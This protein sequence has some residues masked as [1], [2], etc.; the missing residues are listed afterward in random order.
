MNVQA[1]INSCLHTSSLT[2]LPTVAVKM[3]LQ[4]LK[5]AWKSQ[6]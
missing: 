6:T 5:W 2:N 4:E 3:D 1:F